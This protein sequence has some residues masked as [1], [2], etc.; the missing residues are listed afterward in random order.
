MIDGT[1]VLNSIGAKRVAGW[2]REVVFELSSSC[3][4]ESLM[5]NSNSDGIKKEI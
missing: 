5:V 1:E 3:N 2:R 4:T